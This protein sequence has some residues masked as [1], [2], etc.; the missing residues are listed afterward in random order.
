VATLKEL[1]ELVGGTV[2]G[3]GECR[4]ER[5]ATLD[6]AG[7]GDITFVSDPKYLKAIDQCKASAVIV[8]PGVEV[9]GL[10]LIVSSNPYLAFAKVL[11]YLKVRRPEPQGI[12]AGAFVHPGARLGTG[13]TVHP[14]CVVGE[15]VYIG[16][17][18][19]LY[20]GVLLYD[21][22]SIGAD[23]LIHAGVVIREECRL[24]DRVIIQPSA[25]IGS[26]GFGFAPDGTGYYKIPQVG[27]VVIEDDVEIGSGSCIDRAALG[28]TLIKR[29][30]KIDNLVHIAHNVVVG[31][32]N[33]LCAQVGVAGSTRIGRHCT[34][35][36][37]AGLA[38]HV[39]IGDNVMIGA[40]GGVAGNLEG[41]QVLSGSPVIP[42][43]DWIKASLTF[44]RLPE[45]RKEV[46]RMK[47]QL[48]ELE[49]L[50]RER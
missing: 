23:C 17:G 21:R 28:V 45:M 3:D 33:I 26:D 39:K 6:T 38:G 10:S 36:G 46:N 16:D 50:I 35:G 41:N 18:T 27:I 37:Q 30:T 24:G 44:G 25:V 2:V 4:I 20:P 42:H 31:E 13:V 32:D 48:A 15:D 34:F 40:Q 19:I 1:A 9:P 47:R 43:K 22:V 7:P 14:G 11:T 49:M 29:G 8:A 12:L 5:L